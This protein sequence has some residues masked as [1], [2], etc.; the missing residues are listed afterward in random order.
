MRRN[1]F[2]V[3]VHVQASRA[4]DSPPRPMNEAIVQRSPRSVGRNAAAVFCQMDDEIPRVESWL[5]PKTCAQ[6]PVPPLLFED[7]KKRQKRW[8]QPSLEFYGA[9]QVAGQK[10]IQIQPS[11]S[12]RY[13]R[14]HAVKLQGIRILSP[15]S[16]YRHQIDN[17]TTI[18]LVLLN[19]KCGSPRFPSAA[20]SPVRH[21]LRSRFLGEGEY[22][23]STHSWTRHPAYLLT[24]PVFLD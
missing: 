7:R 1:G 2:C 20:A 19:L 6:S 14:R 4:D 9:L 18:F 23:R 11:P 24:S 21:V 12:G 10:V 13:N 22:A 15:G 8:E 17:V 5:F 16:D 3:V